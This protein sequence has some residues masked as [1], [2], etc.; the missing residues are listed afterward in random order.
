MDEWHEITDVDLA[1]AE[2]PMATEVDGEA[3]VIFKAGNGYRGVQRNCPHQDADFLDKGKVVANGAV[4][5][6]MLH[7]YVFKLA[8]GKGAGNSRATVVVYDVDTDGGTLKLKRV[9]V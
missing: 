5:R 1:T 8:T 3:V 7:G 6:C 9:A 2:F 4:L